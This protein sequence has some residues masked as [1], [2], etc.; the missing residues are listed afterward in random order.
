MRTGEHREGMLEAG[1]D[2]Q[3][4][5]EFCIQCIKGRGPPVA[6][7]KREGGEA[8]PG[9]IVVPEPTTSSGELALDK[10]RARAEAMLGGC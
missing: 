7:G 5:R 1:E 10:G 9:V 3:E 2:C 8:E 4:E 6:L